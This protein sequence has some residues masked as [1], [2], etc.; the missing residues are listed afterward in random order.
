MVWF[1]GWKLTDINKSNLL[2][3]RLK[4]WEKC[5]LLTPPS[6][7]AE[8]QKLIHPKHVVLLFL[9]WKFL[10]YKST[11]QK[12]FC[13]LYLYPTWIYMIQKNIYILHKKW[14]QFRLP[15]I[16]IDREALLKL[17]RKYYIKGSGITLH[18]PQKQ[19]E[20]K[21]VEKERQRKK[22]KYVRT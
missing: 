17:I 4:K 1:D 2:V 16:T 11:P 22:A 6:S 20:R 12:Q 8:A 13:F 21:L 9:N 3:K 7:A 10:H 5:P 18:K 19:K 15:K 14:R